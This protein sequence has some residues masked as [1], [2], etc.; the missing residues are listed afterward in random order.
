MAPVWDLQ[1]IPPQY[2]REAS[3][4]SLLDMQATDT[5][6]SPE[7]SPYLLLVPL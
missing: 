7:I 2:H 1:M 4:G 6:L 3:F 5:A